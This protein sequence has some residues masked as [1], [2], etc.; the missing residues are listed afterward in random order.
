VLEQTGLRVWELQ[1]LTWGDLDFAN[2]RLR[3]QHGKT[4]AARRWV[5]CPGLMEEIGQTVPPDDRVPSGVSLPARG[6]R[7]SG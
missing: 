4:R 2:S 5:A 6:D 1:A 3:V 7:S